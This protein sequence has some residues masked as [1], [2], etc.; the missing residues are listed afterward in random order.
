MRLLA[1][2]VVAAH[3]RAQGASFVDTFHLLARTYQFSQRAA[4]TTTMRICRGGG[5]TK[6]VVYLRGLMQI[7]D[8]LRR[9]GEIEPLWLGK[10]AAD[11]VPLVREL[12]FRQVLRPPPLQPRYMEDPRTLEKLE[13][14]RQGLSVLQLIEVRSHEDRIRRQ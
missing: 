6:D 4:Y 5:L 13:R 11:H 12:R 3:Q 1:A 10:I 9:G 14:L 2:R 7:L 8:Y